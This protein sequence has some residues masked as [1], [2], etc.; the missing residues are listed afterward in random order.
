MLLLLIGGLAVW[1][2]GGLAVDGFGD[3]WQV[4]ED[5]L[6]ACAPVAPF[7]VSGEVLLP[8]LFVVATDHPVERC[9]VFVGVGVGGW[10]GGCGCV[11]G[12][13]DVCPCEVEGG[14]DVDGGASCVTV[15]CDGLGG[16]ACDGE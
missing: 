1:R 3:G 14:E 8:E 2:F 16:A 11:A 5:W 10:R 13:A 15:K 6:D 12:V 7:S 4:V 9:A